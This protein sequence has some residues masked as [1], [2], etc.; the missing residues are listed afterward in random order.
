MSSKPPAVTLQGKPLTLKGTLIQPGDPLP[1]LTLLTPEVRPFPL[2][3]TK[4]V[5]L[6]ISTVPSLDTPV[7]SAQAKQIEEKAAESGALLR[8]LV[9]SEDLPFAQKR[10]MSESH[11][12]HVKALSDAHSHA[13]AHQ[14]GLWID[15]LGV[16]TRAVLLVDPKGIVREVDIC[17]ELSE[18][19]NYQKILAR[20]GQLQS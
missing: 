11:C 1:S 5:W 9:V 18:K 3:S 14:T 19:P 17:P 12:T 4:G 6:V 7:C 16:L 8:W 13:F 15:E 2:D 20:L 10:W